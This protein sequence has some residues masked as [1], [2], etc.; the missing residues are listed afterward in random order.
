MGQM[1]EDTRHKQRISMPDDDFP[2]PSDE[3]LAQIAEATGDRA[4]IRAAIA[5]PV[6][7]GR[8]LPQPD[9]SE[10]L[11]GLGLLAL[12]GLLYGTAELRKH[13]AE[14]QASIQEDRKKGRPPVPQD[15][16]ARYAAIGLA[17]KTPAALEA[18]VSRVT[19]VADTVAGVATGLASPITNSFLFRPVRNA[20]D[21]LAARGETVLGELAAIGVQ[22]EKYGKELVETTAYGTMSDVVDV[23]VESEEVRDLVQQQTLGLAQEFLLFVQ[24]RLEGADL[25][26]QRI[27]F[28]IIPG[29]QAERSLA[30][31]IDIPWPSRNQALIPLVEQV[32]RA[33]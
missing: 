10:S 29:D 1:T 12:G 16:L 33:S 20:F 27:I 6:K 19:G 5:N 3:E 30:P 24:D 13:M 17:L 2:D 23:V 18:G 4:E 9:I 25:A 32:R 7:G 31:E 14:T 28:R 11:T 15:D 22:G 26:F 21:L 8:S